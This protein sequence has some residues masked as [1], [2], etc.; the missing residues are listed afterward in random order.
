M[1]IKNIVVFLI[2]NIFGK[3]LNEDDD[4]VD[5]YFIWLHIHILDIY[6]YFKL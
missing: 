2:Q 5:L 3:H 6:F 4:D 1:T